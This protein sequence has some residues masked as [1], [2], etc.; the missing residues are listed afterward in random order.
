SPDDMARGT[1]TAELPTA[2]SP[3]ISRARQAAAVRAHRAQEPSTR[4]RRQRRGRD[5]D[6]RRR[7][8]WHRPTLAALL[9]GTFVLRVWGIKQGLPYSYNADEAIHFVP[10]AVDF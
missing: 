9:I 6:H 4:G 1:D 3:A 7:R 10:R 2:R 8:D 5:L